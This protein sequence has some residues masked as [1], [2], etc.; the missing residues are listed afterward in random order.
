MFPVHRT[1]AGLALGL[2]AS[3]TKAGLGEALDLAVTESPDG[4]L[5]AGNMEY[6]WGSLS[7]GVRR[8]SITTP[9]ASTSGDT[10]DRRFEL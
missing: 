6:G 2:V 7:V 1:G 3:G 9:V 10:A 5:E 4:L 8:R